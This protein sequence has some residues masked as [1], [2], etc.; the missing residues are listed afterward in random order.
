MDDVGC[1]I[2]GDGIPGDGIPPGP[3][4]ICPPLCLR[5]P[6]RL[7][8]LPRRRPPAIDDVL[9]P[10]EVVGGIGGIE[11]VEE[12]IILMYSILVLKLFPESCECC[13]FP[14]NGRGIVQ[15]SRGAVQEF[16]EYTS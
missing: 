4:G 10:I 11:V 3:P 16:L 1:G 12:L 5:L 6:R 7:L 14:Q 15:D 8:R 13:I 9:V 2:P